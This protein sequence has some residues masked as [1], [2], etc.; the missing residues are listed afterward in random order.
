MAIIGCG[1]LGSA[2][3]QR[4]LDTSDDQHAESSYELPQRFVA[5]VQTAESASRLQDRFAAY[6]AADATAKPRKHAPRARMLDVLFG[7]G[8]NVE[9]VRQSTVVILACQ[10]SQVAGVVAEEGMADALRGKLVI[11]I[12]A[13][14]T[15][16]VLWDLICHQSPSDVSRKRDQYYLVHAMPNAASLVGQSETIVSPRPADFPERYNVLT[17]WVFRSIGHVTELPR[18]LMAAGTVTAGCAVGFLAPV[19][20]GI[21]TGAKAAGLDGD[22]ALR[23]AAQAIKG[24]AEMVLAQGKT[25]DDLVREVATPGGCTARGLAV[26][27]DKQRTGNVAITFE[28]AVK[29]A[30]AWIFE[31]EAS[32]TV[33]GSEV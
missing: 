26:L 3:L 15:D 5:C 22:V 17:D 6:V 30:V 18:D 4:V 24:A 23:M 32:S 20:Q 13:G 19:L 11:N 31:L 21:T 7:A 2:I 12:C 16:A 33:A 10:P 27:A 8:R 25:P 29:E 9:A 14:I 1:S 28:E